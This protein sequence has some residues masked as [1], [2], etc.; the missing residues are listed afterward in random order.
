MG[1]IIDQ[2]INNIFSLVIL[3]KEMA[4][5]PL[6]NPWNIQLASEAS[7]I[8]PAELEG[9]PWAKTHAHACAAASPLPPSS[10]LTW[11]SCFQQC[12]SSSILCAHAKAKKLGG[13]PMTLALPSSSLLPRYSTGTVSSQWGAVSGPGISN[14]MYTATTPHLPSLP[15]SPASSPWE[16]VMGL[17]QIPDPSTS[18]QW[19]VV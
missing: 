18:P 2:V 19:P 14:C 17:L 13:A 11:A 12:I 1:L 15:S 4:D 3:R 9:F 10:S 8:Q 16:T 7:R 6:A 5:R